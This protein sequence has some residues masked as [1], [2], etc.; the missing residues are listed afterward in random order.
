MKISY[1]L[2]VICLGALVLRV[3]MVGFVKHPGIADPNEYYNVG[4][5]LAEG[6]GFQTDY[7]W[8]Y[9]NP[10]D[11]VVHPIDWWL[12]LTAVLA[13]GGMKLFGIN[14]QASL[15]FFVI[16]G[17][18]LPVLSY[19][20]ARQLDGSERASLFAAAAAAVLPEFYLNSLRTNTLIPNAVLVCGC[21][22]LWVHWLRHGAV[23]AL[24]A[25]GVLAGLAYLTRS[26]NLLLLPAFIATLAVY[27]L[28]GH[29]I[30]RRHWPYIALAPLV[31]LAV[32]SLW[33]WRN[34][35]V[36]GWLTP[37]HQQRI[38]FWTDIRDQYTYNR[39]LTWETLRASQSMTQIVAKRLFEMAASVKVM[40]T[41]LDGF[42][43]VAVIGGMGLLLTRRDWN[44]LLTLAPTLILLSGFFFFYTVMAPFM[45]QGGSFKKAYLSLVPL[46]IPVGAYA[47]EQAIPDRRMQL[48]T[49]AIVIV[50]MG[51]D[52][53]EMMR[54]DIRFTNDY[55]S[56][57]KKVVT[58]LHTLPDTNGDGR[59]TL[60][61]QD[62]F[63][64]S[65]LGVAAVM[66]PMESRE[67]VLEVAQRYSVDYLMMPPARPSL[68]PLYYGT[69]TDPRFPL[70]Q[71]IRGTKIVIYGFRTSTSGPQ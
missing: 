52:A 24:L 42:L 68:D 49:L 2:F 38:F 14:V 50:L 30:R 35:H 41:S 17:S 19:L 34:Y 9:Y 63:V 59:I 57:M 21:F 26:E 23:T 69:D 58:A 44:R 45:S 13:A 5:S 70:I 22:L 31:A 40:V 54:A 18:V 62:P 8:Q 64:M 10:P 71:E 16:L 39:D 53:V 37:P 32:A 61:T 20:A 56:D 36:F 65:F 3:A 25:S 55:L 27:G 46:L 29:P 51:A 12:P 60:M 33:L 67:T 4:R 43:P 1:K 7:I 66:I 28:S 47:I 48:G 15:L 11:S 6:H